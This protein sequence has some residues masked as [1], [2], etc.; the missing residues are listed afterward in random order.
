[1]I[2]FIYSELNHLIPGSH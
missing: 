2:L 1:M